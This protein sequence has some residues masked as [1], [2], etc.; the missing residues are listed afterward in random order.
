MNYGS[1]NKTYL[2][3]AGFEWRAVLRAPRGLVVFLTCCILLGCALTGREVVSHNLFDYPVPGGDSAGTLP[4]TLMVYRFLLAPEIDA[5]YL[6]ISK[7]GKKSEFI[8]YQQW[9]YNPADMI[10]DLILR[11][12]DKSGLFERTVGQLS[13][14]RY[15]YALE[16]KILDLRGLITDGKCRAVIEAEVELL[17]FEAPL[18]SDKTVMK[19]RYSVE[20][21]CKDDTPDAVVDGLNEAV[22]ELSKRLR[23]DL[24]S[25]LREEPPDPSTQR[26]ARAAARGSSLFAGARTRPLLYCRT[27]KPDFIDP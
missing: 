9:K 18:G 17:D 13:S 26:L 8:Q 15:R 11:D 27:M 21:P 2:R 5:R 7:P 4:E 10:T 19:R 25:R 1:R 3:N 23:D 14:L 6:V 16:G 20:V 12:L 22:R 24:R